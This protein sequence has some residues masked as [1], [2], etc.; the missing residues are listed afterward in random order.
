[1]KELFESTVTRLLS[2]LVTPELLR[3]AES[4]AWPTDLW[5]ALED[6]GFAVAAA[7]EALRPQPAFTSIAR[8]TA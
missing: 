2:D 6:S 3:S 1:M 8:R 5:T 7:P 4:G